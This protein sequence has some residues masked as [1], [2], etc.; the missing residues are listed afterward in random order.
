MRSFPLA[1]ALLY[2]CAL[3]APC[4]VRSQYVTSPEQFGA[5]GDGTTNDWRAVQKALASCTGHEDGCRVVFAQKYLSGPIVVN[6][7][8]TTLEITGQLLVMPRKDYTLKQNFIST[9]ASKRLSNFTITG[10]GSVG[11]EKLQNA[12]SWWECKWL[13][14]FRPHLLYVEGVVGVRIGDGLQLHNSPNHNLEVRS[15]TGTRIDNIYVRAPFSSPNTDGVNFYGGH[16]QSFTNS[17][18]HNG[19]DCVSVVPVGEFTDTCINGD[20]TQ[21]ACRGGNVYVK[22]ITCLGGHGISI[23]G[24][25]HGTVSNVTF[26]NMTA[27]GPP[28]N[29]QGKYSSGGLRVKSYPNSTGEVYDI[30]YS[31]ILLDGVY[32]PLQ[33][34]G[35]YCPWPCKT[36]DGNQ[37]VYFHNITFRRIRGAGRSATQANFACS[38]Y[39]PCRGILLDDVVLGQQYGTKA[40]VNCA[41]ADVEFANSTWPSKCT[42]ATN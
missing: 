6:T 35:R 8:N 17:V 24:V 42:D 2:L 32:M 5:A 13:G 38:P 40:T 33:L 29:T 23:G 10:P 18:V 1:P 12:L 26:E 7:S 9:D 22:N 20:P 31:D 19:D 16:D 27:T 41:H 25:R 21:E 4:D 28:G 34:L 30:L 14:C 37:S 39:A 3:V 11:I 15:C 36:P